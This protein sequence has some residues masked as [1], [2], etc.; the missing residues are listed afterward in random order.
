MKRNMGPKSLSKELR[1]YSQKGKNHSEIEN[2]RLQQAWEKIAPEAALSH[3]DNIVYKNNSRSST[4]LVFLD[5]SQWAAE[6]SLQSEILRIL[7]NRELDMEI[8]EIL[9]LVSRNTAQKKKFQRKDSEKPSYIENVKPVPLSESEKKEVW[10]NVEKISNETLKSKLFQTIFKDL[11]WK[12]AIDTI[13]K[14]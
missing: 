13:N 2:L 6:L 3:S 11:E 4:I 1:K 14:P 8:D 12:K 9:F 7:L 5:S 10:E